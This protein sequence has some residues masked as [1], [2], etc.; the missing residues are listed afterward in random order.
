MKRKLKRI[1]FQFW[2]WK[3]FG[4]GT[5]VVHFSF[6]WLGQ[7][8]GSKVGLARDLNLEFRTDC[9]SGGYFEFVNLNYTTRVLSTE[10]R[11]SF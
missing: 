10:M 9:I 8:H 5:E 6:F 4:F 1:S 3:S 2:F 11:P 7:G